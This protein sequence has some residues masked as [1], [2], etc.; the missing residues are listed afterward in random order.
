MNLSIN[1]MVKSSKILIIDDEP[2]MCK[3]LMT[4]LCTQNYEV[5]VCNSGSEALTL[6]AEDE[7]DLILLDIIMKEM[8]G[9]QVFDKIM[10]QKIDTP[11]IIMT[12]HSSTESAVQALRMGAAD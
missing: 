1:K 2:R 5:V 6:L 12:A 4:L 3:S 11:V 8:G 7:F 9:F 10:A